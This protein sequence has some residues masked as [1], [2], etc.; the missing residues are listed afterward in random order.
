[1][2]PEIEQR[3]SAAFLIAAYGSFFAW[4]AHSFAVK[5]FID[6]VRV[7]HQLLVKG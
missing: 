4:L 3:F 1:L 5:A 7:L 2:Q 6:S